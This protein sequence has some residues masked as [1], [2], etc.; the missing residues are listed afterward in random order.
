MAFVAD[1]LAANR[2]LLEEIRYKLN[3]SDQR[4]SPAVWSA[5]TAAAPDAHPDQEKP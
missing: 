5:D 3:V 4:I 2:M 1:I